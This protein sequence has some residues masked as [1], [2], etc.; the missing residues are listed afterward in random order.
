MSLDVIGKVLCNVS[1]PA[2]CLLLH[3]Q[4]NV[5]LSH[6]A[7]QWD[8]LWGR[9]QGSFDTHTQTVHDAWNKT[10]FTLCGEG[11]EGGR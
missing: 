11:K 7:S 4:T 10:V 8:L 3:K 9:W 5:A 2:G 1:E 6:I